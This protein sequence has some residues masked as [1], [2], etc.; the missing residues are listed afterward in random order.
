MIILIIM[1]IT[2]TD[3]LDKLDNQQILVRRIRWLGAV[4]AHLSITHAK[5]RAMAQ[6]ILES[7][8]G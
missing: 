3:N 5:E 2:N 6:V 7:D 1:I 4:D 8:E